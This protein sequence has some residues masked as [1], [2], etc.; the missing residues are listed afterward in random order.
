M[1]RLPAALAA[2]VRGA[3]GRISTG[4]AVTAVHRGGAGWAADVAG[5]GRLHAPAVV[6]ATPA[7][8]ALG[9]LGPAGAGWDLP[10]GSAITHL[11][12]LLAAPALDA[13]PR[14]SGVLVA[15]GPVRAKALTHLSAKWP[16]LRAAL[17]P[18]RHVVRL[19]YGRPGEDVGDVDG[20]RAVADAATLLG[21]PLAEEQVLAH[22]VVRRTDVLAAPTPAHR[23]RVAELL[24][25]LPPGLAVTG[26][27]VAGTGLAAVTEHARA[28][29]AEVAGAPA[30]GWLG[31]RSAGADATAAARK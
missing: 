5:T 28:V 16:W 17:G 8:T 25:A 9:L 14:G 18:G 11:T 12:L 21:V 23:A 1:H 20:A 22:R 29:A 27:W 10:A 2:T 4:A 26:A 3:G 13:A 31:D 30:G 7:R 19:S 15:P 6:L 24:A